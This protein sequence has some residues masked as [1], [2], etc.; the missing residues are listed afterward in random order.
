MPLAKMQSG[1]H[2]KN[3]HI[4]MFSAWR[5][6]RGRAPESKIPEL[7]RRAQRCF[8][9]MNSVFAVQKIIV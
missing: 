2:A 7:T 3:S 8:L 1:F 6:Q 4:G 9:L 5:R